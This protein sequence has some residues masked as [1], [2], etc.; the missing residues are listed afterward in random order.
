MS[1]FPLFLLVT[2][3]LPLFA[4]D[5]GTASRY[6][7]PYI[8]T[9]CFGIDRSQFPSDDSFAAAGSGIWNNGLACSRR[10]VV[11]CLSS[12][13]PEACISGATVEVTIVDQA[14]GLGSRQSMA[15]TTM[16]L[17]Q[18]A[19]RRIASLDALSIN[20]EFAPEAE[21]LEELPVKMN[22]ADDAFVSCSSGMERANE[23]SVREGVKNENEKKIK[24]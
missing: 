23:R 16:A 10:Y 17:S 12:Q 13:M 22:R 19:Y 8:P 1:L 7:P 9:K 14:A 4:A 15:G 24:N 2:F 20:I 18:A 6:N 11:R 21:S 3:L 5:V